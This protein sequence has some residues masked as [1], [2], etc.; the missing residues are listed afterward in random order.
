MTHLSSEPE[1][2]SSSA[3]QPLAGRVHGSEPRESYLHGAGSTSHPRS[4][5][6][7]SASDQ[8]C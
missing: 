1:D 4:S 6:L 7:A 3:F 5:A 8:Q 2:S